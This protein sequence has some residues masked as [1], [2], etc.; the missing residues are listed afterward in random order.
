[1]NIGTADKVDALGARL[2]RREIRE[3]KPVPKL[4]FGVI[5]AQD[6][7]FGMAHILI[8]TGN[9]PGKA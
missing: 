4:R 1:M 7:V 2:T 8:E 9:T 5:I 3:A 6:D